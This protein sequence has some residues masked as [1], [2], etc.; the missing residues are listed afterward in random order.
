M[1]SEWQYIQLVLVVRR[2]IDYEHNY[3]CQIHD[4]KSI[5]MHLGDFQQF[6]PDVNNVD[7]LKTVDDKFK[8]DYLSKVRTVIDSAY[9][10]NCLEG[11]DK[12]HMYPE[13]IMSH[14][15][16]LTKMKPDDA[17]ENLEISKKQLLALKL[18]KQIPKKNGL[19]EKRSKI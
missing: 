10:N 6:L 18:D 14:I 16:G 7:F 2:V 11:M 17:F 15:E 5:F 12:A 13:E 4:M 3:Y 19:Q 1:L 9:K 8:N